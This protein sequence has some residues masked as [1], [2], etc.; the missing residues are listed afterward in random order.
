MSSSLSAQLDECI[1]LTAE[2]GRTYLSP[3][4]RPPPGAT[5]RRGPRGGRFYD[6]AGPAARTAASAGRRWG[7]N[8]AEF[9]RGRGRDELVRLARSARDLVGGPDQSAT[10]RECGS[11]RDRLGVCE[12]S[13]CPAYQEWR[14][15]ESLLGSTE[16]LKF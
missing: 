9:A 1:S 4:E 13:D 11:Q 7:R 2:V 6:S 12:A 15:V 16:R 8:V 5:A 10:C 14:F 3:G